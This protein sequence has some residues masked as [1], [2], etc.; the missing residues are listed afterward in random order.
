MRERPSVVMALPSV[1][2]ARL[3]RAT[4]L[5]IVLMQVV[6]SSRTMTNEGAAMTGR[7]QYHGVRAQPSD[8]PP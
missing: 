7:G 3:D 1:V 8:G 4:A 6:R 5:N 2:M